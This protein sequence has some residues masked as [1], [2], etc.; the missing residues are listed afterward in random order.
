MGHITVFQLLVIGFCNLFIFIALKFAFNIQHEIFIQYSSFIV[1]SIACSCFYY[2]SSYDQVSFSDHQLSNFH[3][4]SR[5]SRIFNQILYK[6][7]QSYQA[8]WFWH[9]YLYQS[10]NPI[11]CG[12]KF[13]LIKGHASSPAEKKTKYQLYNL[14]WPV[15]QVFFHTYLLFDQCGGLKFV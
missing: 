11:W 6:Y 12:F 8:A 9:R 4:L 5:I 10:M 3:Y 15:P 13:T 7:L 2:F 1:L 14:V